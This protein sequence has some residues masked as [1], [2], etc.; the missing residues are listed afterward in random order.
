MSVLNQLDVMTKTL[1]VRV[2]KFP[3]RLLVYLALL[4]LDTIHP[5]VPSPLFHCAADK[6]S[7]APIR[8][9]SCLSGSSLLWARPWWPG[10]LFPFPTDLLTPN[11]FNCFVCL[12]DSVHVTDKFE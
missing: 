4:P 1:Q 6:W 3:R 7:V 9:I 5:S 8:S 2:D 10:G 11:V 12:F